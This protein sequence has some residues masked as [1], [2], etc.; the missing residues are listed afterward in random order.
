MTKGKRAEKF[1]TSIKKR[2]NL[3]TF[4]E[5]I[6]FYLVQLDLSDLFDIVKIWLI[7]TIAFSEANHLFTK[8]LR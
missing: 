4:W 1:F 8:I 3:F 7:Q 6:W 2:E 5:A